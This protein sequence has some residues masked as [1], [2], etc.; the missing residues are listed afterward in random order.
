MKIAIRPI[1]Q[2]DFK[3]VHK[4]QCQYVDE[5]SYEDFL[6]RFNANPDLYIG[7]FKEEEL[8]GI[9]YGHPSKKVKSSINLQGIAV[10]LDKRGIARKGIG[11]RLINH[12]G[13][14]SKSKGFSKLTVG[15]ADDPKVENF[16]IKNGF[17]PVGLAAKGKNHEEYERVKINDFKTGKIKQ[18]ELRKKHNP[19]EVIFFFDKEVK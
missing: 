16:Y 18:E 12:F 5:E 4:F 3:K 17:Y 19:H 8:V 10:D 7:A 11:S 14:I 9:C 6:K 2:S 13:N 15:S 1:K